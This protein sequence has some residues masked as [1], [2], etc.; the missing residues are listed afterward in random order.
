MKY[1][2]IQYRTLETFVEA[3]SEQE[4]QVKKQEL[5]DEDFKVIDWQESVEEA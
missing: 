2:V 1:R 3:D 5:A 4:L